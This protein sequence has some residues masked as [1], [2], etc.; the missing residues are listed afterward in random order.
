MKKEEENK[1]MRIEVKK[2]EKLIFG[3]PNGCKN[4]K[5]NYIAVSNFL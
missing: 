1:F 4:F 3:F 5:G 2:E